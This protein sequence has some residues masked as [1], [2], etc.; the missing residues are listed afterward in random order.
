MGVPPIRRYRRQKIRRG[1]P[2]TIHFAR[3]SP[4]LPKLTQVLA[5]SLLQETVQ[6]VQLMLGDGL[7]SLPLVARCLPLS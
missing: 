1:N 5:P 4:K 6:E 2:L 3:L 7:P